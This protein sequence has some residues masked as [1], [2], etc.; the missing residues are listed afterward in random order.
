MELKYSAKKIA[1]VQFSGVEK[2]YE[3][4][5]VDEI[6]DDIIADYLVIDDL[7][8]KLDI[9]LQD[10]KDKDD[11]IERL[12]QQITALEARI[13]ELDDLRMEAE[14]QLAFQKRRIDEAMDNS[15]D[16]GSNLDQINYIKA[17]ETE[18]VRLGGDPDNCRRHLYKK[19]VDLSRIKK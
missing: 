16:F 12:H 2:G 1:K 9:A 6:L 11:E 7:A 17:L 10:S 4:A 19:P 8:K 15:K 13:K 3:P 5:E 18:L 14:T